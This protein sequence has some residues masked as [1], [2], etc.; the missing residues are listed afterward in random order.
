MYTH[1]FKRFVLR[2]YLLSS[3]YVRT[4]VRNFAKYKIRKIN[5]IMKNIDLF[6]CILTK[7][8]THANCK[9]LHATI[10]Q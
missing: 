7:N 9:N 2:T 6:F 1:G 3:A 8:L 5:C 10:I 4:Y